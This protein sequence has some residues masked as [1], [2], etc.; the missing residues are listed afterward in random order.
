MVAGPR[1]LIQ[2]YTKFDGSA[3]LETHVY[4]EEEPFEVELVTLAPKKDWYELICWDFQASDYANCILLINKQ[5]VQQTMSLEDAHCPMYVLLK[6]LRTL[7]W[8]PKKGNVVHKPGGGKVHSAD[9]IMSSEYYLRCLLQLDTLFN[10]GLS[11]LRSG[12]TQAYYKCLIRGNIVPLGCSAAD[13]NLFLEDKIKFNELRP[14]AQPRPLMDQTILALENAA[15]HSSDDDIVEP[16]KVPVPVDPNSDAEVPDEDEAPVEN[17]D[18]ESAASATT[19]S[20]EASAAQSL[21]ACSASSE[22]A[23][24]EAAAPAEVDPATITWPKYLCGSRLVFENRLDKSGYARFIIACSHHPGEGC[25]KMRK[26][27]VGQTHRFG[28]CEPLGF[29]AVWHEMGAEEGLSRDDHVRDRNPT[30]AQV[31]EW[32]QNKGY[33]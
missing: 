10:M 31:R 24:I 30:D 33:V 1:A 14:S 16:G 20:V 15:E 28:A 23:V 5:N 12:L 29:L 6:H 27:H 32:L 2:P 3:F 22:D 9:K 19:S 7:G 8:K 13:Y 18:Q 21:D 25:F 26:T 4:A 11:E 17:E